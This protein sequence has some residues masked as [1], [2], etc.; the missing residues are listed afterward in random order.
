M[1]DYPI[2]SENLMYVDL[3]LLSRAT[4]K[5]LLENITNFPPGMICAG[6]ME[7]QKDACQVTYILSIKTSSN[8]C[9]ETI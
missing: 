6:Y 4:C 5:R 7:G 8:S 1:Q 3:P 9:E 2:S